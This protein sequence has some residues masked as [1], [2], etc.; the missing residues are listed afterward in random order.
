MSY[1]DVHINKY[2][3]SIS[4]FT[5]QDSW[6]TCQLLAILIVDAHLHYIL[7]YVEEIILDI[8]LLA[9]QAVHILRQ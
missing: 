9:L 5:E 1:P 3:P 4:F 6:E 8:F 7:L 2:N